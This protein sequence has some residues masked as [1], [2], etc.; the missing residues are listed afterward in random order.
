MATTASAPADD[1]RGACRALSGFDE[2]KYY[3]KGPEGDIAA[4]R[5][6]AAQ[7]LSA[8]AA[9]GDKRYKPV[10]EP[11]RRAQLLLAQTFDVSK[12]KPDLTKARHA[13]GNL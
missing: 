12:M 13:C 7:A 8:A 6:A 9:T 2:S 3:A 11:I 1:A 10:A 5:L 4:S